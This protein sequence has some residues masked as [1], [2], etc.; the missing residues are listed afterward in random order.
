[1]LTAF[2]YLNFLGCLVNNPCSVVGYPTLE[3]ESLLQKYHFHLQKSVMVG[4]A[5]MGAI[6]DKNF[7]KNCLKDLKEQKS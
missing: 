2:L 7:Q 6:L 1:M 4:C 5:H 3:A